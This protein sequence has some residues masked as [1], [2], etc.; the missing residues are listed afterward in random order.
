[1]H[2]GVSVLSVR[3]G[4][5][6]RYVVAKEGFSPR[7]SYVRKGFGSGTCARWSVFV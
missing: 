2:H 5:C 3:L 6:P 7:G 4:F 1:M